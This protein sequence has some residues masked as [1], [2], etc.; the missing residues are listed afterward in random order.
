MLRFQKFLFSQSPQKLGKLL[1]VTDVTVK[2]WRNKKV[3]PTAKNMA[4]IAK[5]TQGKV[6]WGDVAEYIE[7][8]KR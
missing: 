7:T 1:K 8:R 2:L 6:T 3:M 4:R 5:A